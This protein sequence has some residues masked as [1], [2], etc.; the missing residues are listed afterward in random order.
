MCFI[1]LLF[2]KKTSALS[3][4]LCLFSN[5]RPPLTFFCFPPQRSV[6]CCFCFM[7]V[8]TEWRPAGWAD[9]KHWIGPDFSG[10]CRSHSDT[11]ELGW[12]HGAQWQGRGAARQLLMLAL[13]LM[14]SLWKGCEEF[15]R[16][17]FFFILTLLL[18]YVFLP[19]V[20]CLWEM[21]MALSSWGKE[22][23]NVEH[24]PRP[25]T[26]RSWNF[27]RVPPQPF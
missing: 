3:N 18:M 4:R 21:I 16:T 7:L 15:K 1:A 19:R 10:H 17:S 20:H 13:C 22:L 23:Q 24:M 6:Q 5:E 27:K 14:S 2:N 9:P 11:A 26:T 8:W 12:I 25:F